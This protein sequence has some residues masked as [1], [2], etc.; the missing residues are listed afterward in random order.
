MERLIS[1][2]D[3]K[4]SWV[5]LNSIIETIGDVLLENVRLKREALQRLNY[6]VEVYRG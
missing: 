5:Q 4:N 6:P 1:F 2:L 3:Y